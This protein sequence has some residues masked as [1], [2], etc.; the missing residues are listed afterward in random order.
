VEN[1]I[2]LEGSLKGIPLPVEQLS[3]NHLASLSNVN[4][5]ANLAAN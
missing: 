4:G 2:V 5:Q 3:N 1:K